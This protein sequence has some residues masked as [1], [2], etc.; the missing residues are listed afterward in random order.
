[1]K[2]IAYFLMVL[3]ILMLSC[4]ISL[5]STPPVVTE[6]PV[7]VTEPPVVEVPPV[8]TEPPVVTAPP[9]LSNVTC[10]ELSIYL[11]PALASGYNCET[12]AAITEGPEVYPQYTKLTLQGYV[13]S[14]KFFEPQI[15]IFQVSN[16]T[17]LLPD[18][19]PGRVSALQALISGGAT[20]DSLPFLPSFP[21]AQ[22][23]H[24]QYRVLPFLSGGGV[25]FLTEYSQYYVPVNNEDLFYTYQ[26][27]TNDGL[28]WVTAILP[29]NNPILPAGP[30]PLPG[31]A[32][33]EDFSNNYG[34]YISDMV[35]QLNSQTSDSY[36]PTLAALDSLVASIVI[37]P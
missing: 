18:V 16:Y 23:F 29:I 24:A 14:G 26:G 2:R 21:A 33:Q 19:V 10:N 31:G 25:R 27:I 12:V 1:M 37:Q 35:N 3:S 30:D 32:S 6:P 17:G 8:V 28:Y 36:I 9:I 20:G 11:D 22:A 13:L 4:S 5:T 7:V 15:S 34:S